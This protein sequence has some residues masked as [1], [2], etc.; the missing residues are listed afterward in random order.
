MVKKENQDAEQPN[1]D[2]VCIIG[3]GFSGLAT[4][5]RL[6]KRNIP[7]VCIDRT[8]GL[9]GIWRQPGTDEPGPGYRS[10]HMNTSRKVS[11]FSDVPMPSD[12]PQHPRHDQIHDYLVGYAETHDLVRHMKF[13]TEVVSV[14]QRRKS[15]WDVTMV[16]R[17][18]GLESRR[19]FRHVVVATGH[20]WDPVRPGPEIPGAGSFPGVQQH[21]FD[22]STPFEHLDK[23]V[24]VVG[25]GN[26]AADLSVEL[27]R[28]ARKTILSFRRSQH[29]VPRSLLG[30][31]LD[32]IG[33]TRWWNRL[34][35]AEQQRLIK[36][37]LTVVRGRLTDFGIPR[38]DHKLFTRPITISDELLSR[39]G[40]GDIVVKPAIE[41]FDGS[42]VWF[43]DGT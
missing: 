29:V 2:H 41:R 25:F 3:A 21:T 26:S 30:L 39:I 24:V 4:A 12:Y 32:E 40:H 22:Y 34:T 38:P 18:M 23:R 33:T 7:F 28:L 19:T 13:D 1:G 6:R 11:A 20:Q 42:T 43:T 17:R 9:G 16:D 37:L 10:L 31:S 35:F 36:T 27:S 15:R 5:R 14:S 8:S